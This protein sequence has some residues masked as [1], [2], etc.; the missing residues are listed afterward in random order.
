MAQMVNWPG[1][2]GLSYM[3]SGEGGLYAMLV[4]PSDD[5]EDDPHCHIDVE[6]VMTRPD[7]PQSDVRDFWEPYNGSDF[8]KRMDIEKHLREV[9]RDEWHQWVVRT[10]SDHDLSVPVRAAI[11]IGSTS[12][13]LYTT[14]GGAFT[15]EYQHLTARGQ[16]LYDTLK[17]AYQREPK[18]LTF[19]DT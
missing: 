19:L 16:L 10:T 5:R 14:W 17:A 2:D 9:G 11:H 6:V 3:D 13:S 15:V 18:I 8:T 12:A 7:A 1:A 4:V